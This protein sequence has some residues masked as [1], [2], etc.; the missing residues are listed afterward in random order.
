MFGFENL[1]VDEMDGKISPNSGV[2]IYVTMSSGLPILIEP[3]ILWA[4]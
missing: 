3:K 1:F 4:L 2:F